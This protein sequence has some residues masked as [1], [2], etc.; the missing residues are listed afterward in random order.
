MALGQ[1]QGSYQVQRGNKT[2]QRHRLSQHCREL[3]GSV[4][5]P[6][7]QGTTVRTRGTKDDYAGYPAGRAK[8]G[9]GGADNQ[10]GDDIARQW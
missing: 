8:H 6:P 7:E 4:A 2:A 3:R 5:V 9:G 1:N 10:D